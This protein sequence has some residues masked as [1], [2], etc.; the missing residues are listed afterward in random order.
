[1][2]Y[3]IALLFRLYVCGEWVCVVCMYMRL[4]VFYCHLYHRFEA[5]FPHWTQSSLF[6]LAFWTTKF[7]GSPV[8]VLS[9]RFSGVCNHTWLFIYVLGVQTQALMPSEQACLPTEPSPWLSVFVL[10]FCFLIKH[11]MSPFRKMTYDYTLHYCVHKSLLSSPSTLLFLK[12]LCRF[13][14]DHFHV[15]LNWS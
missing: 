12:H 1:M 2:S 7:P 14:C 10:G 15:C 5:G 8:S 9:T 11:I 4:G 3:C 13:K 6:L